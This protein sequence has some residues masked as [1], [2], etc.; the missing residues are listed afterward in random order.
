MQ[1]ALGRGVHL[2]Q[3]G[4]VG[5]A[6]ALAALAVALVG[7]I[8]GCRGDAQPAPSQPAGCPAGTWRNAPGELCVPAEQAFTGAGGRAFYVD[9]Q[10]PEASDANDGSAAAP[11]RTISRAARAGALRPGDAV[12]IRSGIY[13]ESVEPESGGSGADARVTYAAMPGERVVVTG[14]D[15]VESGWVRTER[16]TWTRAW[17]APPFRSYGDAPVFRR[18]L[19]VADGEVL[20]PT[21]AVGPLA[22]GTFRLSGPETAPGRVEARW[23][24]EGSP[25]RIEVATR[26]YLF[27]PVGRIA[28]PD[29]GDPAT[30]GWIRLVGITFR[31]AANRAQWGAVCAGS[32]DGLVEDVTVEWTNGQGISVS[33]R[34]HTFRRTDADHNGQLGWGGSCT[35]CLLEDTRA[36]GNNWKGYDPF[37][38]AGG[39]KWQR[40]SQTVV[41][42]HTAED[43][44]GPGIW[45][46]ID[47]A[48]NTIEHSRATGNEIAGIMLELQTVRTLVQHNVSERT[49][50][51]GWSGAGIL[52]QAASRNLYLHNTVV[53]NEGTGLWLRLDPDRRAPDG[54]NVVAGNWI[55]DNARASEE[56][57]EIAVERSPT[58]PWP[59]TFVANRYGRHRG[60]AL[61]TSSFYLWPVDEPAFREAGFRS[62]SLSTWARL[63]G[64]RAAG[65]ADGS[66]AR[67]RVEIPDA[68]IPRWGAR[69][70]WP[71][72]LESAGAL[73][74]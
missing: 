57:R 20:M 74:R 36:V 3:A 39:G 4:V 27:R 71:L 7:G 10:H 19:L 68:T 26:T 35:G 49:R 33:G 1:R 13:R 50:W 21:T 31:H 70:T 41:R 46:D 42:R 40:T 22:P 6:L 64:E 18:E 37:W 32:H 43:N 24:R 16:G 69:G 38:E 30:P 67:E 52:S 60:D 8:A 29:C 53:D 73:R 45:F 63:T 17:P 2:R 56:A 59:S 25:Q 14:A 15:R 9:A 28:D 23:P 44:R 58:A 11:W 47:N 12:L 62:N 72:V 54:G 65:W 66:E 51:R 55:S 61:Y 48:D 34:D 5:R